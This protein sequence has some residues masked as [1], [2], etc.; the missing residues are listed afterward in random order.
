MSS[1]KGSTITSLESVRANWN[2]STRSNSNKL[3]RLAL[4]N[5]EELDVVSPHLAPGVSSRFLEGE[6]VEFVFDVNPKSIDVEEPAAVQIIPTQDGSQF[7]EH[8]GNIYKN[9][10]IAGTTGLRPNKRNTGLI[11]ILGIP[12]PFAAPNTI[13]NANSG[14]PPGEVSGF[15]SLLK[16]RNLFRAYN[17]IK[18]DPNFASKVVMMWENGK[19][20]EFYV[21]EPVSFKTRRDSSSPVTAMYEIQLRTIGKLNYFIFPRETDSRLNLT[22]VLSIPAQFNE[23]ARKLNF[24]LSTL[25]SIPD[26]LVGVTQAALSTVIIP[27]TRVF[28]NITSVS[29]AVGRAFTVPRNAVSLLSTSSLDLMVS[30]QR[31]EAERNAGNQRGT[32]TLHST[33]WKAAKDIFRAAAQSFS[34]DSLYAEGA[35]EKFNTRN[36]A[37]FDPV[38]GAPRTGGSPTNLSEVATPGGTEIATVYNHDTIFTLALRLLGDAAR[39]KELVILNNLKYPYVDVT[40]DGKDILR[41]TDQILFPSNFTGGTSAVVQDINKDETPLTKRLGRD[42]KLQSIQELSGIET[43]DL[44]INTKGDL[45]LIDGVE[46]L[47]QAVRIKFS[48]EKGSLP[49]H[50]RFGLSAPIGRKISIRSI[51]GFQV[52]TRTSLLQDSRIST[53]NGLNFSVDGNVLFIKA[54]LGVVG[55]DNSVGVVLEA[56]R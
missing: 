27:A 39:W 25:A 37:Y 44:S 40:G 32:T 36:S 24:A 8:Q 14:L 52:D 47:K 17:D 51:I 4:L 35:G 31:I 11:P 41:P 3:Y 56:R 23:I 22:G 46:N 49:T 55:T 26:N 10:L 13:E 28:N 50:P 34:I 19:E 43:F 20:G 16:L 53:V 7:V 54:S 12:N 1:D 9:I 6:P 29:N 5:A 38:T 45:E 2:I 18:R 30:L 33:A 15:E 48:T 42:L 21:V